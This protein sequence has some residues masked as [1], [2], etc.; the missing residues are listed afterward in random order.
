MDKKIVQFTLAHDAVVC[1]KDQAQIGHGGL[2]KILRTF[3][4]A[5]C[6]NGIFFS[7]RLLSSK[8]SLDNQLIV[9]QPLRFRLIRLSSIVIKFQFFHA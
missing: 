3:F 6:G 7:F 5:F 4:Q 1:A 9:V 8:I 2:T